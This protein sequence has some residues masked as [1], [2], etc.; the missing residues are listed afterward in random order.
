MDLD[1]LGCL[2]LSFVFCFIF[3]TLIEFLI[4]AYRKHHYLNLLGVF[5][6]GRKSEL[7]K[8]EH[9]VYV[10]VSNFNF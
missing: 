5:I 10:C 1:D 8:G 7:N 6:G 9:C 3:F 2:F 4:S